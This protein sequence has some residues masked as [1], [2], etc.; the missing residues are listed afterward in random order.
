MSAR[1]FGDD[2][3]RDYLA[4]GAGSIGSLSAYSAIALFRPSS[5]ARSATFT[6]RN[7][8]GTNLVQMIIDSGKWFYGGDFSAGYSGFTAVAE[9]WTWA[10]ISHAAGSNVCRWHHLDVTAGGAAVHGDGAFA[11]ANPGAI[12]SVRLG[13]GDNECRGDGALYA[14]YSGVL[15]DAQFAAA[16]S[17]AASDAFGLGPL[18]M[19]LGDASNCETDVT[20]GGADI[21][22]TFGTVGTSTDPPG[23]N[24]ALSSVVDM[25]GA[26]SVGGISGAGT[27]TRVVNMTGSMAVGGISGSG[28]MGGVV[29]GRVPVTARSVRRAVVASTRTQ[30]VTS[31]SVRRT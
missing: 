29:A 27:M 6:L 9:H 19:W 8:G 3:T 11:V 14:V 21:T 25:V 31:R 30:P 10:G 4:G 22:S 18:A 7:A 24:Y 23:F 12:A 17:L 5:G 2:V 26:A 28:V 20:G 16:F 1:D 15:S 13:D